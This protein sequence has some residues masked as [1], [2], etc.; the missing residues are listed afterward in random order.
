MISI[1]IP[2]KDYNCRRLVQ[3][4]QIQG[5]KRGVPYEV[6]VGEDG[7]S[8]C[9]LHLNSEVDNLKN[10]RR[11]I[12]EKSVG[13]AKIRNL[14][15]T[16]A[17]YPNIIFIDCDAVVEKDDFLECYITALKDNNVVCGSLYHAETLADRSCSLRFKYEK[18]ADKHRDAETRRKKPFE[19]FTTFNF[20]I[21]R[22]LFLSIMFDET[23]TK[24]GYEDVL[25]GKEL[26][27]RDINILHINNK[28]L[29]NG[30]DNNEVFLTKVEHSLQTLVEIKEKIGV[31]PLLSVA[32][33]LE[34]FRLKKLFMKYWN[35]EKGN[36]KRNLLG[37][38]PSLK[39]L[40]IY[41]LGYYIS[42]DK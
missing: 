37:E 8:I 14:L 16:E 38:N 17:Q 30:L 15:A 28:L 34:R 18:K 6:L 33:N 2:S 29:H 9:N 41:K 27:Q 24:Y 32:N 5:E 36:L 11:I 40:N 22:E 23:I 3:T 20:A 19:N 35:A 12:R 21:K 7:T 25:F 13:R 10:C 42:I 39:K 31:T 26:E 4:L 1:L